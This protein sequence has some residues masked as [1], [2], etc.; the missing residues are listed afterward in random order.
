LADELSELVDSPLERL[1][2]EYKSWID[3]AEHKH[4]AD[5][6]RHIAAISNSGGGSIVFGIEDGG[7]SS[8]PAPAEFKLDHDTVGSITK[9]YLEPAIHCDV[10]WITSKEGTAHPV[11]VVP[12][13]GSTPICAKANGPNIKGKIEGIVTGAYYLRKPGP[14]SSQI[15]TAAEWRDVIRRC[16]LH[17][18]SAILA[19]VTAALSTETGNGSLVK[20]ADL[21][22][23]WASAADAEYVRRIAE[24]DFPVPLRD[25][26]IQLSYAVE[27]EEAEVLP[28]TRF[29]E[30][31][32]EVCSEVDQHVVSGW[33]LFYVFGAEPLAPRWSFD[34][35]APDEEFMQASL[36]DPQRTLGFDFW[37]VSPRGLATVIREYWEDTPDFGLN[38][39]VALNPRILTR[40]VGELLWHAN[41]FASRF[42]APL[43]V[44][45][46]CQWR[47]LRGRRLVV[48]NAIPFNTRPAEIDSIVTT[49]SWAAGRLQ[50]DMPEIILKL[51]GKVARAL[52]W[53]GLTAERIA[54][55]MPDWKRV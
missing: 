28:S 53:E 8:G 9:K 34:S 48:P 47:G 11:I 1:D 37:R 43:R 24:A 33:S 22:A 50:I 52:D 31:L 40:L 26:R 41:A 15:V 29:V 4:R 39:R 13:H 10:R 46:R 20:P 18:R 49:G 14:E 12:S 3:L 5:L 32:R 23:Q 2:V 54:S 42:A 45:F 21:L 19:A 51:T 44:N 38:P 27:T 25:C 36:V 35:S 7:Q 6:A 16:A 17:D 30:L 55:E